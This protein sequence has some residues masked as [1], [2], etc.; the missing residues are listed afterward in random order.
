MRSCRNETAEVKAAEAAPDFP[1]IKGDVVEPRESENRMPYV[2]GV[3]T[4]N[5]DGHTRVVVT[6]NDTVKFD[7]MHVASPERLYFD[8]HRA[9]VD[10]KAE[11]SPKVEPGLLKSVRI[12]QNK[13]T[14][15][16]VV[17]DVGGAKNYST[18]FLVESVSSRD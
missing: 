13:P 10:P 2:T 15:V 11:K 12:G 6:L 3:R 4:W 17:L 18:Q 8:L 5:S 7:S 16:R 9:Q 1:P 14:V